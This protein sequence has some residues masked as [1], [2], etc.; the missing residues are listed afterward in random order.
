[1][2]PEFARRLEG[3]EESRALALALLE[4]HDP[5]A[6]NR[7]PGPGRWSALQVLHHVVESEASALA[8]IR[9]KMRAGSSLPHAGLASR[10][11]RAAVQAGLASP[12]RF[13]APAATGTVPDVVDAEAL[14]ARWSE[15]RTGLRELVEEFPAS[16]ED[17]VVLRHPL[18]GLMG[19]ADSLAVLQAHLDH[20]ARQVAR[21]LAR[22]R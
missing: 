22:D 1:M 6:W 14:R 9:K 3:L 12:F 15:V 13:R 8:Y 19:L 11:R 16:L 4:P 21:A 20:H 17:R 5:A 7:P 10:L 2:R 18:A